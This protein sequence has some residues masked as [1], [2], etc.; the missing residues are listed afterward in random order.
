MTMLFGNLQINLDIE[1]DT[2]TG[3]VVVKNLKQSF[4]EATIDTFTQEFDLHPTDYNYGIMRI[5][6]RSELSRALPKGEMITLEYEGTQWD[7]KCHNS[8]T[9]R[10]DRFKTIYA[11]TDLVPSIPLTA[12]YYPKTKT[13]VLNKR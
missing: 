13:I 12:T 6:G 1:V 7:V 5:P 11:T 4:C 2:I 3:K 10:L 8:C 9:G